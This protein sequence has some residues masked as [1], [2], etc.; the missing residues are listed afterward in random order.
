M[1]KVKINRRGFTLLEMLLVV[2]IISFVAVSLSVSFAQGS[3]IFE[4]LNRV[5][6]YEE[7]AILL[8]R[9]TRDYKNGFNYSLITF[10]GSKHS[11]S[12]ARLLHDDTLNTSELSAFPVRVTYSFDQ[13][14]KNV[15]YTQDN[16]Y[17]MGGNN[18]DQKKAV[19]SGITNLEFNFEETSDELPSGIDVTVQFSKSN[20]DTCSLNKR[21]LAASQYSSR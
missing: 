20:G 10:E 11:I 18:Y 7:A 5:T 4:K 12:F 13:N 14:A 6:K 19:A 2:S 8:E 1:D 3:R 16:K 17:G 9:I 21:I 15:I